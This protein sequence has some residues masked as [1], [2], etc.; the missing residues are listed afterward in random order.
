MSEVTVEQRANCYVETV[1]HIRLVASILQAVAAE[2]LRR[3]AAHDESKLEPPEFEMFA[4]YTSKLA[5]VTYGSA[6]YEEFRR[7]MGPALAHHYAKN[8]H[9]P[10]HFKDGVND[11]NLVQ[12]VEML[13]DWRASSTRHN[14]G[15]IR[16][17]IEVNATRFGIGHQLARI[18]ENTVPF[19]ETVS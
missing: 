12:L 9:H 5:G 18:L 14:D 3:A 13:C 1:K 11:M 7:A 8:D 4:E 10:E 6:E 19:L 17:S 15:N 2:L 16:K